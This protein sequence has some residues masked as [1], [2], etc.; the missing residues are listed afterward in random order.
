MKLIK[1]VMKLCEFWVS[2]FIYNIDNL[3]REKIIF[4][5]LGFTTQLVTKMIAQKGK[6]LKKRMQ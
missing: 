3:F 2:L 5:I 1:I 4:A 6:L